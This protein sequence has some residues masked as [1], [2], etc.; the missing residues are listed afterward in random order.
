MT[1]PLPARKYALLQTVQWLA[2]AA[3]ALLC[4]FVMT[5]GSSVKPLLLIPLALCISAHF[6]EIPAAAVG[7]AGGLLTD[8]A[9]GKLLGYNAVW[10]VVS[11]V[12]TSLLHSYYLRDKLLNILLLT[13]VCTA[14]QGYLDFMFYYA[15]WGHA[16]V[17]L[18]YT[19]IML[20]SGIMTMICTVP[21]WLIV[22]GICQKCGSRRTFEL[23][24]TIVS[25][26]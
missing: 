5:A 26:Q 8:I 10:L 15:I 1:R 23:E 20:P 14:V 7:V 3:L 19:H 18:I 6:G 24:K 2:F 16:D 11:C 12:M 13:A 17:E 21:V 25:P 4:F 9:C 22:R